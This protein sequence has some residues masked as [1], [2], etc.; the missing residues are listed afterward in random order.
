MFGKNL[1]N[2]NHDHMPAGTGMRNRYQYT[3]TGFIL[4][5]THF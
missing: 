2:K 4:P 3:C 5:A 1:K